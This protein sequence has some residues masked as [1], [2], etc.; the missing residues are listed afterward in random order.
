MIYIDENFGITVDDYNYITGEVY[1]KSDG[2]ILLRKTRYFSALS[3]AI[4]DVANRTAK[5]RLQEKDMSL[6]DAVSC[7]NNVY[8]EFE[9]KLSMLDEVCTLHRNNKQYDNFDGQHDNE[10]DQ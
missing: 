4:M 5:I 10:P 9:D 3:G 6:Y 7:L 8:R 2:K 1:K